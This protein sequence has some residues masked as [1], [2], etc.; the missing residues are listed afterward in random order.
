MKTARLNQRIIIQR[1][2]TVTDSDGLATPK[3]TNYYTCWAHA[4]NLSGNEFW[5]A[6]TNNAEHTVEFTVRNC[7][8]IQAIDTEN[9]QVLFAGVPYNITFI[10]NVRY[11]NKEVKIKATMKMKGK[12]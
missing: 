6:M 5:A 9:Y 8:K 10:D 7:T 11:E 2:E 1:Y 4:N 12:Q 3:W